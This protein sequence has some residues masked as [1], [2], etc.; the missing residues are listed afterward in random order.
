MSE[1]LLRAWARDHQTLVDVGI[2]AI[3]L[4][5]F[6]VRAAWWFHKTDLRKA[7]AALLQPPPTHPVEAPAR[8]LDARTARIA[9]RVCGVLGLVALALAG[10]FSWSEYQWLGAEIVRAPFIDST[11]A[12]GKVTSQYRV[13]STTRPPFVAIFSFTPRG[14]HWTGVDE[15][16]R[17]ERVVEVHPGDPLRYREYE[18]PTGKTG[19]GWPLIELVAALGGAFGGVFLLFAFKLRRPGPAG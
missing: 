10:G 14:N 17:R 1:E 19:R 3:V 2:P 11:T 15:A 5:A 12:H 9:S 4:L 18:R 13:P 16:M 8:P 6:A 7:K